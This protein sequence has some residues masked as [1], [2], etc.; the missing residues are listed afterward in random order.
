MV[1]KQGVTVNA[2]IYTRCCLRV[3]ANVVCRPGQENACFMQDNASP[4]TAA[5][6][7][8]YLENRA[9]NL[10]D[11]WPARSPDLNPIENLWGIMAR[12][13]SD[14]GPRDAAQL[15]SFV[16]QCWAE[17]D[18]HLIDKLVLSFEERKRQVVAQKGR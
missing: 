17:L 7:I 6:S 10:L 15:E 4:H 18:Q 11:G 14:R 9:I 16:K 3:V 1:F 2:E 5:R 8:R 12:K 13:V